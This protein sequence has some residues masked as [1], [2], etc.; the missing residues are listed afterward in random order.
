MNP[1]GTKTDQKATVYQEDRYTRPFT[2]DKKIQLKH[3]Q[4]KRRELVRNFPFC[5]PPL[6][7]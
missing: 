1:G 5:N 2:K 7:F 4:E 6:S 3:I